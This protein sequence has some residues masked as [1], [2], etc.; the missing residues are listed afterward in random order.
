[1][2]Y[3]APRSQQIIFKA[4]RVP[5]Y[6]CS[7]RRQIRQT[8]SRKVFPLKDSKKRDERDDSKRVDPSSRVPSPSSAQRS[9]LDI[10]SHPHPASPPIFSNQRIMCGRKLRWSESEPSL[11]VENQNGVEFCLASYLHFIWTHFPGPREMGPKPTCQC[12]ALVCCLQICCEYVSDSRK[13]L[14]LFDEFCRSNMNAEQPRNLHCN[15]YGSRR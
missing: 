7:L 6:P 9:A 1:M 3:D 15:I 12:T 10:L 5:K 8:K 4:A 14:T 2:M 11:C 13:M